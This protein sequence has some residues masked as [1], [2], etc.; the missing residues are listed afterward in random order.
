MTSER[1][2][3]RDCYHIDYWNLERL[4]ESVNKNIEKHPELSYKD[5]TFSVQESYGDTYY[6]I[7]WFNRPMTEVEIEYESKL[8]KNRQNIRRQ[9]YE[10]LKK[11]FDK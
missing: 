6:P 8:E 3:K 9:Q 1:R 11:E 2:T 5:F 10:Q 4:L 7:I